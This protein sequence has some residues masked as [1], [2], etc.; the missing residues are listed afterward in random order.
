VVATEVIGAFFGGEG[1]GAYIRQGLGNRDDHEVQAGALLITS[2][3]MTFD[4]CLYLLSKALTPK[5]AGPSR[6]TSL[7]DRS[8]PL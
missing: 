8:L 4:L 2:V 1:L 5:G 3:A 7:V 6:R